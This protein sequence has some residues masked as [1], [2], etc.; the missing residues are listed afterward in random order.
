[1]NKNTG[2]EQ[3]PYRWAVMVYLAGDNNLSEECV[4]ALTEM[5]RVGSSDGIAVIAQLNS[6][7]HTNTLIPIHKGTTPGGLNNELNK[8]RAKQA[9]A[10]MGK[11]GD[12][13]GGAAQG[14]RGGAAERL[15][16]ADEIFNFV[17]KC[18]AEHKADRYMLVLS[19][20]GSGTVG[21]FLSQGEA[22][23]RRSLTVINLGQLIER[24]NRTL[25]KGRRLDVLGMDSCLMSMTEVAYMIHKHVKVMIGAEGFEPLA[26]WPYAKVLQRFRELED[27]KGG[28][29]DGDVKSLAKKIVCDYIRY[30]TDYQAANVSVDQA[31]CD[32]GECVTLMKAVR[33]L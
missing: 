32:L 26:G 4:F 11:P 3:N 23:R 33:S 16:P 17:E 1:M 30:Y 7:V 18:V 8:A 9:R 14:V 20:H 31:A 15:A 19:G 10:E 28:G 12:R 13:Q 24:I 25:L 22:G 2:E 27:K 6:G 5:R 29:T 21:D